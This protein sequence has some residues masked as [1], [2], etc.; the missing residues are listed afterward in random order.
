[1][2]AVARDRVLVERDVLGAGEHDPG[3]HGR[4]PCKLLRARAGH[5]GVVVVVHV[6]AHEDRAAGGSRHRRRRA[7]RALPELRRGLVVVVLGVR[8]DARLVVVEL[9]VLDDQV[10][11][12]VG[13]GVAERAEL[14]VRVDKGRVA[15]GAG[16]DVVGGVAH[17]AGV[18][19]V[20][21]AGGVGVGWYDSVLSPWL[22][23][24]VRGG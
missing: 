6:I 17:V 4:G 19:V 7:G 3:P 16:A 23:D 11:A 9:R 5:A 15:V 1:P 10:A 22:V 24:V 12:G 18:A 8:G 13:A 21:Q 20:E 14:G 2:G